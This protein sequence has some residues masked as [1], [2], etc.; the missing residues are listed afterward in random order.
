M[1]DVWA[2]FPHT[3]AS[4]VDHPH[5]SEFS[6]GTPGA[7]SEHRPW[8]GC[9]CRTSAEPRRNHSTRRTHKA[10]GAP[11]DQRDFRDKQGPQCPPDFSLG[12]LH[13]PHPGSKHTL[14]RDKEEPQCLEPSWVRALTRL[15]WTPHAGG[16]RAY[17]HPWRTS[18][19][20]LNSR[21]EDSRKA[22]SLN[23]SLQSPS[24]EPGLPLPLPT[25]RAT[26]SAPKPAVG[27]IKAAR[28]QLQGSLRLFTWSMNAG[29]RQSFWGTQLPKHR[30]VK[31]SKRKT[32]P[33][34]S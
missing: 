30:G 8:T 29:H 21:E 1:G 24:A 31:W 27:T 33:G 3:L 7:Q 14:S 26:V 13:C 6:V 11:G 23:S 5:D 32:G 12:S 15:A 4:H 16:G 25:G 19:S 28:P 20:P 2:P 34:P 18:R 10:P 22:H 17:C 9:S